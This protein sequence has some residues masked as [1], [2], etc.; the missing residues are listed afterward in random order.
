MFLFF[1]VCYGVLQ[2]ILQPLSLNLDCL[3]DDVSGPYSPYSAYAREHVIPNERSPQGGI[4][5]GT[6]ELYQDRSDTSSVLSCDSDTFSDA[7]QRRHDTL[8]EDTVKR[9]RP[10]RADDIKARINRHK[11]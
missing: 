4:L 11:R 10:I 1:H 6:F 9:L 2:S 3:Q 5:R 7:G 8:D